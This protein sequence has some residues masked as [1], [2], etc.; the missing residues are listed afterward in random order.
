MGQLMIWRT[1]EGLEQ[2]CSGLIFITPAFLQ[3]TEIYHEKT[4]ASTADVPVEI[5]NNHLQIT[6]YR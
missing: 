6:G 1:R 2:N 4:S 5:R 3:E